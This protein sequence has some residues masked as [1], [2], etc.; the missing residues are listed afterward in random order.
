M[1]QTDSYLAADRVTSVLTVV[2]QEFFWAMDFALCS[3]R[4]KQRTRF[5]TRRGRAAQ[6]RILEEAE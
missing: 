2:R 5:R 4:P 6:P 1:Q 3:F